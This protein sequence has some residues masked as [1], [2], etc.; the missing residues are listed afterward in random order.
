[1]CFSAMVKADIKK[2][3]LEMNVDW[4]EKAF[5]NF[6]EKHRQSP[7]KYKSIAENPRIFPGYY[8]PII[9]AGDTGRTGRPMRY[10]LRPNWA[11]KEIPS[12]YNLFNARLDS[13]EDRKSWKGI[14]M[15]RHGLL[16]FEKFYE[17][18]EDENGKKRLI[19]FAPD[20]DMMWAPVLWDS[21]TDGTET[22]ESFA[23]I[24][25]DPPPEVA[26]MGHD[27]CPVFLKQELIDDWLRPQKTTKKRIY[28]ILNILEDV[29]YKWEWAEA[30]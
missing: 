10:R 21:W 3:G 30:A 9:L 25:T 24:T 6:D 2:L 28:E 8:A 23:M 19:T 13:L 5:L 11:E 29:T 14:F 7:K 20:R 4:D 27:R 15:R 17:W 18:V 1:M 16:C 22:I 26:N 12:K